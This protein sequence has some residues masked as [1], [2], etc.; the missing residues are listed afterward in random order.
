[1]DENAYLESVSLLDEEGNTIEFEHLMT[2]EYNGHHYIALSP[3]EDES[4]EDMVVILRIEQDK[5]GEDIYTHIED[6]DE[7]QGAFMEFLSILE[8]DAEEK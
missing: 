2:L 7:M 8:E 1:M 5:N 6:E 4:E 3:A